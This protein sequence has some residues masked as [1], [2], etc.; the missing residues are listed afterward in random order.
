[1]TRPARCPV[2]R[3]H[4]AVWRGVCRDCGRSFAAGERI[5]WTDLHHTVCVECPTTPAPEAVAP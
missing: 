5:L 3:L 2:C 1:M 4:A